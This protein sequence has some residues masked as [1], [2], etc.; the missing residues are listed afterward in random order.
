ML[1][2]IWPHIIRV[3]PEAMAWARVADGLKCLDTFEPFLIARPEAW[4]IFRH[5][6]INQDWSR[7]AE[8]IAGELLAALKGYR[9]PKLLVEVV[10]NE[11]HYVSWEKLRRVVE[12]MEVAGVHCCGPCWSSGEYD[13]ADW[14]E[15]RQNLWG[16]LSV[17][18]VHGYFAGAGPTRW[19]A[20]RFHDFWHP[21][22]PLLIIGE[23]GRDRV[24]DG[25]ATIDG[26]WIGK[27]GWKNDGLSAE[28]YLT[29]IQ[30]YDAELQK[31]DY[32]LG[33]CLYTA[34]AY[35]NMGDDTYNP[36]QT[37][38]DVDSIIPLILAS[39][40]EIPDNSA[41]N[42]ESLLVGATDKENLT[43]GGSM[44][45]NHLVYDLWMK[46]LGGAGYNPDTAL[47]KLREQHPE[48]GVMIGKEENYSGTTGIFRLQGFTGGIAWAEVDN[49]GNCGVAR[50]EAELPFG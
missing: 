22:D 30:R 37:P 29:E 36:S 34:G 17:I 41:I 47:G 44:S 6:F 12:I 48:L 40:P 27:G 46:S 33:A 2:K 49:W 14:L 23:V 42:K 43:I 31:L 16:G 15:G 20:L 39:T 28:D 50:T 11:V 10:W 38:F 32:V 3:T 45:T 4:R 13:A 25:D 7:S 5:F 26:G 24:R 18:T 21:I 35:G 1:T 19:N 8:D 9:H